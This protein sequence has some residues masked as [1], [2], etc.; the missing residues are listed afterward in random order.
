MSPSSSSRKGH[1]IGSWVAHR[2]PGR[3]ENQASGTHSQ[4]QGSQRQNT[5]LDLGVELWTGS[6]RHHSKQSLT[7][8]TTLSFESW[9]HS[10]FRLIF[11]PWGL[12]GLQKSSIQCH[13]LAGRTGWLPAGNHMSAGFTREEQSVPALLGRK[14]SCSTACQIFKELGKPTECQFTAGSGL[15][16]LSNSRHKS[17]HFLSIK[18]KIF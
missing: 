17:N 3:A 11:Q 10:A 9:L 15:C 14:K 8:P 1:V 5:D 7:P 18:G 4:E 12:R 13:L 6:W 16:R 2:T